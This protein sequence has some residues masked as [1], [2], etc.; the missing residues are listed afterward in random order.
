MVLICACFLKVIDSINKNFLKGNS[1]LFAGLSNCFSDLSLSKRDPGWAFNILPFLI[2]CHLIYPVLFHLWKL[3]T[4]KIFCRRCLLLAA[5]KRAF[6]FHLLNEGEFGVEGLQVLAS[7]KMFIVGV[8]VSLCSVGDSVSWA[9]SLCPR[10]I[11]KHMPLIRF[12]LISENTC[13]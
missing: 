4:I 9:G 2:N 8:T 10:R 12:V 7:S 6:F 13:Q 11:P 1:L 3:F 5:C